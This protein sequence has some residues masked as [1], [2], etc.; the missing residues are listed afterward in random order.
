MRLWAGLG[1]V[2]LC[3]LAAPALAGAWQ[4]DRGRWF[5]ATSTTWTMGD[6][7]YFGYYT[8]YYG[9]FG[10]SDRLTLGIDAGVDENGIVTALVFTRLP[11]WQGK[12]GGRVAMEMASGTTGQL[13]LIRPG[14]SWGRGMETP[15]GPG[16]FAIDT[17]AA[18]NTVLGTTTY[19]LDSTIGISPS[20]RWKAI[21]QVQSLV[22]P[23]ISQSLKIAPS[24]VVRVGKHM[25]FEFGASHALM[26]AR[27][28][29]LKLGV[30][31][32]F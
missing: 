32:D 15:W 28:T 6:Y 4:R 19:K 20:D 26:G 21:F 1:I 11:L 27:Q 23:G 17:S 31:V 14:V 3:C 29:G 24:A 12:N 13:P 22:Q 8:S 18:M 25:Q 30:W 10:L 9:E 16:W 7:G 2:V 5:T